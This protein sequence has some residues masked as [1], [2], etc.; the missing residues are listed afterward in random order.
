MAAAH[1]T[2]ANRYSTFRPALL[3]DRRSGHSSFSVLRSCRCLPLYLVVLFACN[4]V[5][6]SQGDSVSQQPV[7]TCSPSASPL[8]LNL[9]TTKKVVKFKCG[10]G[11]ELH[12]KQTEDGKLCGN[13]ACT[14]EVDASAFTFTSPSQ[15]AKNNSTPD[16]EYSLGVKDNLP[17][18]P[19]TVYFSCNPKSSAGSGGS[20]RVEASESN[21][22]C[23]VQVSVFSQKP[24]PVPDASKLMQKLQ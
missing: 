12:K 14:K 6:H 17:T 20:A 22:P 2:V 8:S 21:K 23:V 1:S 24:T 5:Q 19:L 16:T 3:Q 7:P 18:T 13:I 15:R 9:T 4:F 10:D 11:L